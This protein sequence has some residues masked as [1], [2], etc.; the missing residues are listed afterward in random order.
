[1]TLTIH[2]DAADQGV[3]SDGENV[4]AID[5][6]V[7]TRIRLSDQAVTGEW[8][9]DPELFPHLNSC[10][11]VGEELVCAASNY[12]ALPQLGTVE[13]FDL[14]TLTH[15]SSVS[16]GGQPGSL[17]VM[18]RHDGAW[19]AVFV[20]YDDRGTP[21]GRNH[22]DTFLARM[23]DDFRID[24]MWG[25]PDSVLERL[26]PSSVSG[27]S[28][29]DDGV[30]YLSGHDR[31][32]LYAVTLPVAGGVLRHVGTYSIASRGQAIDIDPLHPDKIWFIDRKQRTLHSGKLPQ[33]VVG[34]SR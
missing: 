3:A 33:A 13:I 32:E 17:T 4:Y 5:N 16:L 12:P 2:A 27:G 28:W 8:R 11:V 14:A 31:P 20:N 9:G 1:M 15:K 29:G 30:L 10:T 18:D 23:D 25:M 21:V 26:A 34:M 24:R 7:I 22:R 19:W 6:N